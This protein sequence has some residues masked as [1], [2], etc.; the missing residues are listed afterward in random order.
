MSSQLGTESSSCEPPRGYPT[1]NP[2]ALR[3]PSPTLPSQAHRFLFLLG[4]GGRVRTAPWRLK[5]L[6]LRDSVDYC[7]SPDGGFQPA[8]VLGAPK[9]V[10]ASLMGGW[11]GLGCTPSPPQGLHPDSRRGGAEPWERTPGAPQ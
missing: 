6:I 9:S 2:P 1:S 11:S 4:S 7:A 5:G 8:G 10:Q 3:A